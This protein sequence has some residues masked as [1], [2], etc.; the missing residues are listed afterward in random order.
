MPNGTANNTA[1]I[2]YNSSTPGNSSVGW[3]LCD[4]TN[5]QL[6]ANTYGSG[7][8]LPM[9]LQTGGSNRINILA[10]GRIGFNRQPSINLDYDFAGKYMALR[11]SS[12]GWN[13]TVGGNSNHF[14]VAAEPDANAVHVCSVGTGSNITSMSFY[15]AN[16]G[17]IQERLKLIGAQA[18][19]PAVYSALISGTTRDLY[20][21]DD[22]ELG[23]I[24]STRESKTN[25][26]ELADTSWVFDLHPVSFNRRK[27][28]AQKNFT[29]EHF[30]DVEFGLIAEEVEKV[31][32]TL[33]FY[34]VAEDGTKKLA[35]VNYTQ[36]ISPLVKAVKDLRAELET[37]KAELA[38]LK[39]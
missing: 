1:F 34:D 14:L 18:F 31:Q 27:Q 39:G 4:N 24:S 5:V 13:G 30:D 11:G 8:A 37:V 17:A 9:A 19:M 15:V 29:D 10:D 26:S 12:G 7:T 22:G 3:L 2:A 23:Y 32:S 33:C 38:A 16:G 28:D 6:S 35:G 20:I 25:I 36:L 21:K